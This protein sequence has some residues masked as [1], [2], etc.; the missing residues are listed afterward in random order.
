MLKFIQK[1]LDFNLIKSCFVFA[2]MYCF[3]FNMAVFIHKFGYYQGNTLTAI[4]ELGKD[5]IY[6][7]ITLFV[8]FFGLSVHRLLFITGSVILFLTGAAASYYLFF[9]SI[10]PTPG[11]MPTIYGTNPTEAYELVST[12]ILLWVIFS[13]SICLYSIQHFN[14]Q[15]TKIF[16][17]RILS[18]ICLLLVLTNIITP[19]FSFLK[20]YFPMQ[21]LHNSYAYFFGHSEEYARADLSKKYSFIDSSDD[22]VIGVLIIGESARYGNFGINGYERDTT[23]ELTKIENLASFKTR[24]CSSTTYLSIPCILSRH[25]EEHLDL[26]DQETS[27]LSILTHLGFDTVW[28][29]TQSIT[30][31]Y[32][33]KKGGT[34]YDEVNFQAIPGGSLVFMPNDDDMKLLPYLEQNIKSTGKKFLV[35]HT[36]GSH[37]NYAARYP[38]EFT[39]F[40]PDLN[41]SGKHDAASC[42]KEELIN[43]YDNS[44]LYTDFF[45]SRVINALQ[46]KNAFLIYSSD[47]GESLG[48]YG[49][50]GH[51]QDAYIKEQREVPL[52]IWTSDKYKARHQ[53]KW[54]AISANK[55]I[56]ISH[57]NIFHSIL[58]CLNIDSSVVDKSLSLCRNPAIP[59]RHPEEHEVRRRDPDPKGSKAQSGL[60]TRSL[61]RPTASS[62]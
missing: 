59:A 42:D 60:R 27:M 62:G 52:I 24:S 19:K 33:N 13:L 21:Y 11:M 8:I 10:A 22:D 28:L 16:F 41:G 30:K 3:L 45:L 55:G 57:D 2:L 36:T 56:D 25:G 51:G 50:I 54:Q 43:S 14:I 39:K 6:L 48:E 37:W 23:P 47:H 18:A 35:L 29:G 44:I 17:T 46:D 40:K 58:D 38:A 61:R 49:N 7:L 53:D 26:I 12:R 15:T 20:T 5:F 31:S 32:R 9:F 1:Q 34:F 4:L